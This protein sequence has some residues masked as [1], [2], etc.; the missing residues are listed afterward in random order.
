MK[1]NIDKATHE[2]LAPELQALYTASGEGFNLSVDGLPDVTGLKEKNRV[3]LEEKAGW[4][5]KNEGIEAQKAQDVKDA[6]E[7][8]LAKAHKDGDTVALEASWQ[9]KF[10]AKVTS[11][12][13]VVDDLNGT[14]TELTSGAAASKLVNE[15]G[16]SGSASVLL[17]HVVSRL[18]TEMVDGKPKVTVLGTDGKPSAMSVAELSEEIKGNAAF[19][20]LIVGS[21][22]K[23]NG[24]VQTNG[25][26][27]SAAVDLSALS[28]QQKLQ[29]AREHPQTK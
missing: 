15:I 1:Y 25:K 12:Q 2:A 17:P 20:P 16:I 9:S 11:M 22:G 4:K 28:G 19:A 14:V 23:G 29:Y 26:V 13:S 10:D 5:E 18:R 21:K 7:A 27:D 3:L 24:T 6:V 8:A